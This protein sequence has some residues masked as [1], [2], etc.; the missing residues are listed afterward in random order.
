MGPTHLKIK[1][2]IFE[3]RHVV[4]REVELSR[5]VEREV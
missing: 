1:Q 4:R 3:T 5:V 2:S